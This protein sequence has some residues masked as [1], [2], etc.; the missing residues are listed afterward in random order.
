MYQSEV[1]M[2]HGLLSRLRVVSRG[3]LISQHDRGKRWKEREKEKK[4]KSNK[5]KKR[6]REI[7]SPDKKAL[8]T[9]HKERPTGYGYV[10]RGC[11]SV[12]CFLIYFLSVIKMLTSKLYLNRN[13]LM[14]DKIQKLYNFI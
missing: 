9:E 10:E 6:I 12:G 8:P 7:R 5:E 2:A 11:G 4:I 14:I 1:P 13:R 3:S